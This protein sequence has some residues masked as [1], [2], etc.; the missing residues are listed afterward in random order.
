MTRSIHAVA[1]YLCLSTPL[2]A[3]ETEVLFE[4]FDL[5]DWSTQ[6][7]QERLKQEFS[8][9]EVAAA[10]DPAALQWRFVSKGI[11]FNDLFLL[12]PLTRP[13]DVIRVRVKNEGEPFVLAMKARDDSGAE[14][15]TNRVSLTRGSDWQ[16][17]EFPRDKW[18]V[19]SWSRDAEGKLDFP[20]AFL[21]LIA[22]D[23]KA[24]PEY[25]LKVQRIEAVRPD[26]PVATLHEFDLPR[27][28]RAGQS[29]ALKL[30]FSLDKPCREDKATLTFRRGKDTLFRVPLPLPTPLTAA[31]STQRVA[32][33]DMKLTVPLYAS[34]GK[35]SAV[36][37]LGE[38]RIR[39]DGKDT[40]GEVASVTIE[41]RK[42]GKTLA[43]VKLH[44]GTPTLFVNGKPR[45]GMCWATYGPTPEVFSDFTKAGIDLFTFSGTPTEAGYGLSKTVW[46]SP[47]EYDYSQF[48]ERVLMLLQANPNA[49][50][51]PRLYLHAPKWWSEQHP[52]DVVQMDPGDGKPVPFIH[53]GGKPA[54]S[55]ASEAWRRDTVE[56]LKR[57]I[58]HVEASP[59]ADRVVGYHLASG[60]TEEWMMWGGN[61]NE[62]VDYSPVN[63]ARFRQW[64]K[65]KY[66]TD[67]G[68][69]T[70]WNA[71]RVTLAT[72]AIPTKAQRQA[73]ELG[74]LRDPAKEQAVIDYY[75]YNSALVADTIGTFAKAVKG[76]TKREKI[77]GVFYGYLLQ[78]CGEQRQQ[79]GGHLALEQVLA[80]PDVDFLC[81]P[82]SYAF[83]QLGGEGTSHFMSLFGSVKLHGKLW[84]DE[85]DLRTSL[86]GGQVGEWGRPAD[87]AGDL[88][89]QDKELANCI[90]NGSAQWWFDVGG[91]KYS[92]P[93]LMG[94]IGDLAKCAS[95]AL[96]LDRTSADEV[97]LIVDEN[98]LGYLRPGE[99]LGNWLL[100]GQLPALHRIG[101]P[102]G[103]Y[104]VTDLPRLGARK[105]F[106]FTTSFAP[107]A[108][109]RKAIDALKRDGH[110][111]VFLWAAGLYRD[112]VLSELSDPSGA[113]EFS[114]VRLRLSREPASVRVTLNGGNPLT[115]GLEGHPYGHEHKTFPIVY[116][117]DPDA[118]VL[119]ALDDGR[120]G[121]VVKKHADWT[122]IYSAAPSLPADLMRRMAHLAGVH[123]YLNTPDVVWASKDLLGVCVKDAGTRKIALPRKATVRDLYTGAEI[124]KGVTSFDADFGDRATRVFVVK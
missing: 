1:L 83:R 98:S 28:L 69:Q 4:G 5:A 65:A 14:W 50:F 77:T 105:L 119:G 78:L 35:L 74:A 24:G 26:P 73:T 104:L 112:G 48:D 107:T 70:A 66:A 11:G 92:D 2:F 17:A 123:E 96:P 85:N 49:Y 103:H 67:A 3:V 115:D 51:F 31:K 60:T 56:G 108:A 38:A 84:F 41:Q 57:L 91:N 62:W 89:Q 45:N 40:D 88:V 34:G 29:F 122:A 19:A 86:S 43:Q 18:Q 71:P 42:P 33:T 117:D 120:P 59:Y 102:V 6:R 79:N 95:E 54:P 32:L 118:Q 90:V 99:P 61:E 22:F 9:S 23:V 30:N 53:S 121:L 10:K 25:N 55:W 46:V 13:F 82:T 111:L 7:D 68:L 72:A 20:L 75:L 81:S 58:A 12:K 63:V 93:K 76:F 101:A 97:A 113:S 94:R 87:I 100:V 124:A 64:L 116:A 8:L 80:S 39:K 27:K 44:N 110:V 36:L 15:T 37:Q 16:W 106:F 47:N 109:D 21:T 114:G 52:D